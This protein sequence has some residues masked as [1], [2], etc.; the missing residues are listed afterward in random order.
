MPGLKCLLLVLLM[1]GS[2]ARADEPE[3]LSESTSFRG[4]AGDQ[5]Q[6]LS[7]A[8]QR[9]QALASEGGWPEIP[10]GPTI[11]PGAED[12][13]LDALARRLLMSG[14]LPAGPV[15]RA[16]YDDSLEE[17]VQRFQGRHGLATDGLVGRATLRALNATVERR[18]EQIQAN[19]ERMRALSDAD[20]QT[21]L[22]VNIPAFEL[23]L[24][25]DGV[26]TWS[27]RV[28]VGDEED[29]TPELRSEIISVVLNPGWSVPH[30]IASKELLPEMRNDPETFAA[31]GYEVYDL[32]GNPVDLAAVEWSNYSANRFPYRIFQRP[33]PANQLGQVKFVFPNPYSVCMHD[34]P[35]RSLF[36]Y[37]KRALSHGCIR[38]EKPLAL[39]EQILDSEGWT[40]AQVAS[41]IASGTTKT[42]P[43]S[44][45]LPIYI[46]Y[47]TAT[48]DAPGRVHFY[49]D[50]YGRDA[51]YQ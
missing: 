43:L 1:A 47:W 29:E 7:A 3:K 30:S 22:L 8:L 15:R 9:F 5:Q 25:R 12:S 20:D 41:Q 38:L 13:R 6:Q 36:A 28:I 17:A 51:K 11:G 45:P 26:A 31:R 49:N 50:I 16:Y 42:I 10:A 39:A 46:V 14:D 44:S 2:L 48:V 34:T 33:G 27:A 19:L 24:L 32:D 40:T 18:M 35:A 21:L 23:T 37:R 4:F